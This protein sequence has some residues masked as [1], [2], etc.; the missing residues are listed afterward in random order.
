[1]SPTATWTEAKNYTATK[2]DKGLCHRTKHGSN[3]FL[4][5]CKSLR[6]RQTDGRTEALTVS[7]YHQPVSWHTRSSYTL[8]WENK[9]TS[10]TV[11]CVVRPRCCCLFPLLCTG[12]QSPGQVLQIIKLH[13]TN[14]LVATDSSASRRHCFWPRQRRKLPLHR[15]RLRIGECRYSSKQQPQKYTE[16]SHLH[17]PIAL[18]AVVLNRRQAELQRSGR[19]V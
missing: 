14:M 12:V 11:L 7:Q 10:E 3:L 17:T 18:L 13:Y 16:L 1:M 9:P 5:E 19:F 2:L 8:Q 6:S 4:A 15:P